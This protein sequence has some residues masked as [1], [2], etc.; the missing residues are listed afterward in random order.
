MD[1][2]MTNLRKLFVAILFALTAGLFSTGAFA[3]PGHDHGDAPAAAAGAATPRFYAVSDVFEL[4]G[5]VDG[6]RVT[7]YLDR[8]ADNRPVNEASV[9]LEIGGIKVALQPGTGGVLEGS[10]ERAFDVGVYP[11]IA[12]VSAG[13]ENDLLAGELDLHGQAPQAEAHAHGWQ[14]YAGIAAGVV[15]L[16]VLALMLWR[17]MRAP[18]TLATR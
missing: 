17:R 7:V 4:V 2:P 6:R 3:G 1:M 8:F 14:E 18:S 15:L 9:D 10:L 13:S 12:N 5:L 16:L 11:V